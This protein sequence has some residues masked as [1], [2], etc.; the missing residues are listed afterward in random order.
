MS[1]PKRSLTD[2]RVDIDRTDRQLIEL[3][4]GRV[5]LVREAF[6]MKGEASVPLRDEAREREIVEAAVA[7][8][9]ERGLP[10]PHVRAVFSAILRFARASSSE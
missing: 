8:G 2:V 7:A 3:L 4:S 10:E 9:Q 5:A 1:T 6:A